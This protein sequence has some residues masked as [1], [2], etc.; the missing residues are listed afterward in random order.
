M[1]C[2]SIRSEATDLG[3]GALGKGGLRLQLWSQDAWMLVGTGVACGRRWGTEGT[4]GLPV[5]VGIPIGAS[6]RMAIPDAALWPRLQPL[7]STTRVGKGNAQSRIL[8]TICI[9]TLSIKI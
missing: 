5:V 2:V 9:G 8:F 3:R 4:D 6:S 7:F 1:E